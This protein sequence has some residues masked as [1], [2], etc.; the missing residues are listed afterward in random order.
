MES[1]ILW[2]LLM[3]QLLPTCCSAC[4]HPND[5]GAQTLFGICVWNGLV[6]SVAAGS[7]ASATGSEKLTVP[8]NS[9]MGS[10]EST[11]GVTS[12]ATP[13]PMPAAAAFATVIV[14]VANGKDNALPG[15]HIVKS[16]STC[17]TLLWV[18]RSSTAD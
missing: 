8:A 12:M 15:M 2:L 17:T 13:W 9:T 5:G 10:F 7:A 4:V 16:S 14:V 18:V 3:L 11:G 6:N 1:S